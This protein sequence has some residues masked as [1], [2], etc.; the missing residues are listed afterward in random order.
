MS[1]LE[2]FCNRPTLVA[3]IAFGLDLSSTNSG[4]SNEDNV[5]AIENSQEKEKPE[6]NARALI[7]GLLGYGKGR[8]VFHLSMDVDSVSV[9]LN[10]EDGSRLAML[11][12]ESFLLDLKVFPSSLSIEGTLGNFRLCD[13]SLGMNHCWGWLC[14]IRNQGTE[15][16]IKFTF[17]SHSAED[18]DYE[19]YDY[20]L[21]GRLSG[22][23]IV[24]LYRFVQE[25][26]MYFMELATP[27]TEEAIEFVDK[28]GGFEWLIKKYEIEGASALKLDLSLDTPII[29]VPKNSMSNDFMQLDLGQLQVKN[30][31][32]WHGC[33]EKDPS[34]VHIDVIHAEI[35]GINMAVGVNGLLGKP[36]IREGQG[37][38]IYVRRSLRDIFRKVPTFSVDVKVGLLHGVMSDKEYSVILDCAYMNINEEPRLPPSFRGNLSAPKDTIRMIA[39]KVNLNNQIFLRTV[40]VIEVEVEYALLEL[41]NGIDKESPLAHIAVSTSFLLLHN[42]LVLD[43]HLWDSILMDHASVMSDPKFAFY[44]RAIIEIARLEAGVVTEESKRFDGD[45]LG[46]KHLEEKTEKEVHRAVDLVSGKDDDVLESSQSKSHEEVAILMRGVHTINDSDC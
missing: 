2:F 18:D 46:M 25:V 37:L 4:S 43:F 11:V 20:S 44:V 3:L 42:F 6:E 38:H 34:A 27:D 12:Q 8:V 19:G 13:M 22:V 10:K 39:D 14:D 7:K 28:V 35:L 40:T 16:L 45:G 26:T 9:F 24:F 5:N 17:N 33:P 29:I 31:F 15:S 30:K 21:S 36:M 23:R 41:C 1:K 32:S